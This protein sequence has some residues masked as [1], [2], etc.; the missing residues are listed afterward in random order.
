M[1][2]KKCKKCGKVLDLKYFH[3]DKKTKD[4]K[5]SVCKYCRSTSSRRQLTKEREKFDRNI[6]H[7]IYVS[8]KYD[9]P[10]RKWERLLGF[11]LYD[12]KEHLER[13]LDEN[14]SW[15][16]F[17]SY[18]W[19]DKIIPTRAYSYS[20]YGEFKKCWSLKNLRPLQKNLVMAKSDKVYMSLIRKYNLFD[21]M[22]IG[23]IHYEEE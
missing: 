12:L 23:L 22:P 8:L 10:G 2:K 20:T 15:D 21:I 7:S 19:I 3:T 16:N 6:K 4:G 14:M 13:Q 9:K 18:W 1:L 17:G 11:S 5:K